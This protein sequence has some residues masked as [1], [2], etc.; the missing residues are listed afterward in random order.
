MLAAWRGFAGIR[1]PRLGRRL[2]LPDRNQP[3]P[4]RAARGRPTSSDRSWI[5]PAVE[6]PEPTQFAEVTWL[7]PYPDVLAG[8]PGRCGA[9]SGGPGTRPAKP[10]AW[11]SSPRCSCC[12][13]AARGPHPARCP[14]LSRQRGRGDGG[15]HRG[16]R[17]QRTQACPR[18]PA[19]S[20]HSP[21]PAPTAGLPRRKAPRAAVRRRVRRPRRRQRR[22]RCSPR[23]PGSRCRRCRSSTRAA[24]RRPG[25][26]SAIVARG[27]APG[28]SVATR[29]N[30]Q[31]AWA[32]PA[33]PGGQDLARE[34][35]PR[36]G[37]AREP[38]QRDHPV[39]CQCAGRL[40]AT[41]NACLS[42]LPGRS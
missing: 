37:A 27:D 24:R 13:P 3:V 21:V 26:F 22:R 33:G 14:R 10:S 7:Q 18:H 39:R 40:R 17:D 20:G 29:A 35:P 28:G 19:G 8:P 31:P 11:R 42:R 23:T 38:D 12:P 9:G 34:R 25:F 5:P 1:R 32:L 36:A 41:E 16:V 2:A 6:P 30:G 15:R 4:E